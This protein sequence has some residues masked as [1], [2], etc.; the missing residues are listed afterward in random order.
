MIC[1][2]TMPDAPTCSPP[3]SSRWWGWPRW[4]SPRGARSAPQAV[5]WADQSR[6]SKHRKYRKERRRARKMS[7]A[8][9]MTA[10]PEQQERLVRVGFIGCGGNARGHLRRLRQLPGV[11]ITGVCDIVPALAEQAAEQTGATAYT[12]YRALLDRPDL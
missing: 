11:K 2:S 4:R 12:D 8:A 5:S 7:T 6:R 1:T 10:A 9:G 3:R